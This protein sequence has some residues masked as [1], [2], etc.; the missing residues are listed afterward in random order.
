MRYSRVLLAVALAMFVV[1]VSPSYS[2]DA[3]SKVR[4]CLDIVL[5]HPGIGPP[6]RGLVR[7]EDYDFSVNVPTGF[8]GWG[9]VAQSAPFH[10]F[11]IFLDSQGQ[12]CIDFEIH[13]RVN[14][15][16]TAE[17]SD[18]AMP[19]LL[20][21]ARGWQVTNSGRVHNL[22]L[23]NVVTK[24]TFRQRSQIDDGEVVLVTPERSAQRAKVLYESFLQSLKLD[25]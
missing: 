21:K 17:S 1:E 14:E 24:F 12:S 25:R 3:K 8:T 18:G 4:R 5:T 23:V 20:G 19:V 13:I 9:G 7:N 10:G 6:Y 15:D 22:Q 2:L 11:T 16:D